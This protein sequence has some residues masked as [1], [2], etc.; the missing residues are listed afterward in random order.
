[1]SNPAAAR[2]GERRAGAIGAVQPRQPLQLVVAKRLDTEAETVD[3]GRAVRREPI[4]GD[5][6]RIRLER[7]FAIA[8]EVERV[9]ARGD[10]PRDL[11]RLE[12]RRRAAAEEDR[13]GRGQRASSTLAG[14]APRD[15]AT[16]RVDVPRPS[17]SASNRPRLKLQ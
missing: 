12:Q 11:V 16:Q 3:A 4:L 7:D 5:A 17:A 14:P 10:D 2:L 6:F 1:M 8:R 15:L 13:V 9:L